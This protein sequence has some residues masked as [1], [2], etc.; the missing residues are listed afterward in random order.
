ALAA[1]EQAQV[2]SLGRAQARQQAG[3]LTMSVVF[4]LTLL[5][6]SGVLITSLVLVLL[7]V[8]QPI[9]HTLRFASDI[10]DARR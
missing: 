2:A 7:E 4:A 3:A 1:F 10:A 6:V 9:Q 8:R 5:L